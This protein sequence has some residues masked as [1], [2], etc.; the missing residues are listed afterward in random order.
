MAF[1]EERT[2]GSV[3]SGINVTAGDLKNDIEKLNIIITAIMPQNAA[4]PGELEI[5]PI[6]AKAI[7]AIVDP[8]KIKGIRFPYFDLVLVRG[9]KN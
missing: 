1:P 3:K 9:V 7:I 8:I 2:C 6:I 5:N 4:I